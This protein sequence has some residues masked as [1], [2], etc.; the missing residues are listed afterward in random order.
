MS[1]ITVT[2]RDEVLPLVGNQ[3]AIEAQEARGQKEL[4]ESQHLPTHGLHEVARVLGIKVID[5]V[6]GDDMFSR[7]ELPEGWKVEP[8]PDHSMWSRLVDS[9]GVERA[10]VFYK[11]AFYDRRAFIRLS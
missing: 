5:R 8:V 11:A 7:V 9:N 4:V 10:A 6:D 3:R 2:S 1:R